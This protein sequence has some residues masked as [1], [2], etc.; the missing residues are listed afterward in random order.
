VTATQHPSCLYGS[1][2]VSVKVRMYLLRVHFQDAQN[3]ALFI[4]G[5][6]LTFRVRHE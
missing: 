4:R 3:E 2:Y 6:G 5:R 1:W